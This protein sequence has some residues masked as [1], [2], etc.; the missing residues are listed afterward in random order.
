[1]TAFGTLAADWQCW[2]WQDSIYLIC[3]LDEWSAGLLDQAWKELWT[4]GL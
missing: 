2:Y 1:M 4:L 3:E